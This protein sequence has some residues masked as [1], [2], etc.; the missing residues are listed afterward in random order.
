MKK[1]FSLWA[2]VTIIAIPILVKDLDGSVGNRGGNAQ[3][4]VLSIS[5]I[6]QSFNKYGYG[7]QIK[8]D[9]KQYSIISADNPED[10][11]VAY[12]NLPI[13]WESQDGNLDVIFEETPLQI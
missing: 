11:T 10:P 7:Q 8:I 3:F 12:L 2:T 9:S 6:I 4:R 13:I 5:S 1:V